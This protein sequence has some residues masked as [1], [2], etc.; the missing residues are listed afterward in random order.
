MWDLRVSTPTAWR[1]NIRTQFCLCSLLTAI[2]VGKVREKNIQTKCQ[3]MEMYR[4]KGCEGLSEQQR[5]EADHLWSQRGWA[6]GAGETCFRLQHT[7]AA[8]VL[9][10]EQTEGSVSFT[11]LIQGATEHW[12]Q[13]RVEV[14]TWS[15]SVTLAAIIKQR[16]EKEG[17]KDYIEHW[18]S[19]SQSWMQS[20]AL[21]RLGG[22]K[23]THGRGR[24]IHA[25]QVIQGVEALHAKKVC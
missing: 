11:H 25:T 24:E 20:S 5:G 6:E 23:K 17:S 16:L 18:H 12:L 1:R 8:G 4:I 21:H 15:V 10:K 14:T 9:I 3:L 13:L 19:V 7:E 2:M 22:A